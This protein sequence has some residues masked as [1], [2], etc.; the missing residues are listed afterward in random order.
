MA[1]AAIPFLRLRS[2]S[3]VAVLGQLLDHYNGGSGR[4]D[5]GQETLAEELG[6]TDRTVR[7][8]LAELQAAG[9][10]KAVRRAHRSN[11]YVINLEAILATHKAHKARMAEI[12]ERKRLERRSLPE[13]SFRSDRKDSS[14]YDRKDSSAKPYLLEPSEEELFEEE[15]HFVRP[16]SCRHRL[17]VGQRLAILEKRLKTEQ[18]T[19]EQVADAQDWLSEIVDVEE[20]A[21]PNQGRAHRLLNRLLINE[22]EFDTNT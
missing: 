1:I 2:A 17:T 10:V 5:P 4:C 18:L 20:F 7:N 22:S 3:A 12:A 9:F 16:M 13:T 14:G 19:P 8:A 11:T 15:R 21:S 6:L